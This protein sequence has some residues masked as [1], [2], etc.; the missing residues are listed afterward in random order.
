MAYK[1]LQGLVPVFLSKLIM[2]K[3]KKF[4]FTHCP[5]AMLVFLFVI[6]AL[7]FTTKP[8]FMLFPL[9]DMVFPK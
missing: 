2:Q 4:F 1:A 9:P 6:Y 3:K 7:L 5:L 8:L